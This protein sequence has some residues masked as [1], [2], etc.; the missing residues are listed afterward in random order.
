VKE[1]V[2]LLKKAVNEQPGKPELYLYLAN[3][4]LD[5]EQYAEATAVLRKGIEMAPDREDLYF[6][7]A[8]AYEKQGNREEM[9]ASL[10]KVLEIKPDHADA[11]NYLGYTYAEAGEHLDE[12][13]SLIKRALLI[14][15]DNGYILD[16]LA[17]AYYQKGMYKEALEVMTRALSKSDDDPV[18][19]EHYGDI[20]L[21]L[22]KKDKAKEEWLHSLE[23]DPKNQQ[24]RD[25]YRKAGFGDPD[26]LVKPDQP[27][28]KDKKEKKKVKP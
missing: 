19:R 8:V 1:A 25:R 17:W 14:K 2:P 28:K 16:S 15:K 9:I 21:K 6:T 20:L 26:D 11:L 13:V 24:L 4:H 12:A 23:L 22:G 3:A 7:L 27:A 5:L 18:M 10:K